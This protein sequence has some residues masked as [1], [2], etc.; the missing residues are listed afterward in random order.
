MKRAILFI[1]NY[2]LKC[3]VETIAKMIAKA[4]AKNVMVFLLIN[5]NVIILR[6]ICGNFIYICII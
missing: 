4:I 5:L 1:E 6:T 3:L 2:I